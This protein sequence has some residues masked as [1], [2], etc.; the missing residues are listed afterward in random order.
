MLP[1]QLRKFFSFAKFLEDLVMTLE[2]DMSVYH[3]AGT[4]LSKMKNLFSTLLYISY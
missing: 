2:L 4:S 3:T 1:F